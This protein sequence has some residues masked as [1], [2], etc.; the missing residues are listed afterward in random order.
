MC[1]NEVIRLNPEDVDALNKKGIILMISNKLDQALISF[2]EIIRL[3]P[4]YEDAWVK[5]GEIL[6]Q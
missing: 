1:Y 2:N 3:N 5:K 4:E 6:E